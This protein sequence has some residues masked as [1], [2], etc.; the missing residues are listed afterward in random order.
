MPLSLA[1]LGIIKPEVKRSRI[2][3][4]GAKRLE[5]IVKRAKR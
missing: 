3:K 5:E 1:E 2:K 4:P